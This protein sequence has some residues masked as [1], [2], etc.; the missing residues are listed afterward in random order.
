MDI[1]LPLLLENI[2]H[3]LNAAVADIGSLHPLIVHFPIALFCVAP[4]FLIASFIFKEQKF[5]ILN[6]TC[7]LMIIGMLSGFLSV[8]TGEQS[9]EYL[10]ADPAYVQ[11]LDAHYHLAETAQKI[12]TVLTLVLGVFLI[13]NKQ[14]T[15]KFGKSF[16]NIFLIIF[17]IA[18][19]IGLLFLSNA[20]HYGGKLVH[21]HGITTTLYESHP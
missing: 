13:F 5:I 2:V 1:T 18:H 16:H 15:V 19:M 11:T 14:L 10:E 12:F 21:K 20:A 17:L 6:I 7:T 3:V 9:A 4:L 8:F